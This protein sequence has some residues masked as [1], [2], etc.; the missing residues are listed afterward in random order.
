M[1]NN[2]GNQFSLYSRCAYGVCR[3]LHSV[4]PPFFNALRCCG[5]LG[6]PERV[7]SLSSWSTSSFTASSGAT[8]CRVKAV[9]RLKI[10]PTAR[11]HIRRCSRSRRG[12]V[13]L[14]VHRVR[15]Y[16]FKGRHYF[17]CRFTA[18]T[19]L[20]AAQTD[21]TDLWTCVTLLLSFFKFPQ[22]REDWL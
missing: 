8:G 18:Y 2:A 13:A 14:T 10:I 12:A 1:G 21:S 11:I 20:V 16:K 7:F 19:P 4:P 15:C 17:R 5:V 22:W 6:E 3:P 9:G